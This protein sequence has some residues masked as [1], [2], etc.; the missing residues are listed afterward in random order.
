MSTPGERAGGRADP[1]LQLYTRYGRAHL[2]YA[3]LGAVNT[4]IGR[5]FG[6]VPAF[7]IGLAVD[8]IF[9]DQRAFELPLVPQAW[10]PVSGSGQLWFAIGV[11]LA[12]TLLGA[13]TSWFEDWGWSVFA[14]RIQHAL[15]TDAYA[16]IQHLDMSYFTGQ[17]T[18]ELI[19]I[20][21]NDVNALETFL[22]DGLNSIF[23]IV[24]TFVGIGA[25]LLSLNVPLALITLLPVP[26][27]ALFTLLFARYV[28]PR[29]LAIRGEIGDL[30][31]RFE[32]NL[33]GIE[34]I[35]TE[36][37]EAFEQERVASA[38]GDYLRANLAAIRI[39]ITYFPG[40]TVISGIGFAITFLVGGLWVLSGPPFGLSG[41]LSPGEFVTFVIY[42]QQYIWPI[43]AFGNVVDDYERARAAGIRV[44]ALM[45]RESAVR[46]PTDPTGL[47][48]V[49]GGVAYDDV[50]F[51]YEDRPV[52]QDVSFHVEPGQTVGI[53]GPT[54]AGK[55]TLL[56]LLPR[57]YDVDS[58]AVRV[59]GVDVRE[60]S[61]EA[62]R[63]SIGYVGQ[64]PFLFFG[65]IGENIRY[66][67]FEATDEMVE[68]AA[69]R[70]QAHEF[71]ENLP[72]GYETLVGERGVKLSGGQRQR[73][74]I[75]RTILK[76]P[77]ILVLDEATS[78][79]DTETEALIQRS[80][81]DFARDRTTFIIAHRLSTVRGADTILVVDEGRV[82]EQGTHRE[83]LRSDGLYANFWK[84]QVGDIE[85][86]GPEFLERAIERQARVEAV[87]D[88]DE[89]E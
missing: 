56:K 85:G 14:Q 33:S 45:S 69:R 76:D 53:V 48:E 16:R 64:D 50:T 36:S 60:V 65:T 4:L 30:N 38:S 19:S 61:L 72:E 68:A 47:D 80:M 40:L 35:K 44:Q 13:V 88:P 21:N 43:I 23:W 42:A 12:A 26:I 5:L 2:G 81:A 84:V 20:L 83:L 3:I 7:I 46:D 51:A 58:G 71:I 77:D 74:A 66:G 54:G 37:A 28:E 89:S 82:V 22:E 70:A 79:V 18:G 9:L 34:T 55:S 41:S 15:R 57:L 8:A 87:D 25:I 17:R 24:A 73:V 86:L 1:I 75:A 29:Y 67:S 32:N 78:H 27:L 31:A 59:D 6:L 11:L 10:I 49:E 52:I 39:K 62:L 63:R